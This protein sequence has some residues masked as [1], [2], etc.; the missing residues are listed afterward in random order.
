MKKIYSLSLLL[1]GVLGF[2]ACSDDTANPYAA[3]S[4]IKVVKNW[5][6]LTAAADEGAFIYDSTTGAV[7]ATTS[8][9]WCKAVVSGDTIKVSVTQNNSKSGRGATVTLHRGADSLNLPVLQPGIL[10]KAEKSTVSLSNDD[11]AS[12][13]YGFSCTVPLTVISCPD[14]AVASIAN[15]SLSVDITANTTGHLRSGYIVYGSETY[16]DSIKV[17]QADFDKDIAGNYTLNYET[18]LTDPTQKRMR[19]KALTKNSLY[20]NATLSLPITYDSENGALVVKSGSYLGTNV[21]EGTTYQVYLAFGMGDYWSGYSKDYEISAEL[22]YDDV[23]GTCAQFKGVVGQY[24]FGSLMFRRFK[25][26]D[27]SQASDG[28]SSVYNLT[29]PVIKRAP[30]TAA[31]STIS[32]YIRR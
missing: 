22:T 8:A 13:R 17:Y 1:L 12:L 30:T 7:T 2:S 21:L 20:I 24:E 9:S 27:F 3:E 26:K 5:M 14:W 28:S 23:E 15:D 6:D 18:S 19:N 10:T 31:T 29:H 25:D 4:S 16:V 32:S 11:A